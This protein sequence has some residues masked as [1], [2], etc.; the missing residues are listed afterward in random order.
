MHMPPHHLTTVQSGTG[1]A[2]EWLLCGYKHPTAVFF[3]YV[4][5]TFNDLKLKLYMWLMVLTV[6]LADPVQE[7][8]PSPS[9]LRRRGK[10]P[11]EPDNN[12][13]GTWGE[14]SGKTI[15]REI[16]FPVYM[17]LC[18]YIYDDQFQFYKSGVFSW[19]V[20]L[21]PSVAWR[22]D[23]LSSCHSVALQLLLSVFKSNQV[24]S[25]S[26]LSSWATLRALDFSVS[27]SCEVFSCCQRRCSVSHK[28][29]AFYQGR[30]FL[31]SALFSSS[32]ACWVLFTVLLAS[33]FCVRR[34]LL[35]LL[36][37]SC[38]L[39]TFA[40]SKTRLSSSSF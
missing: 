36:C 14:T 20:F 19:R 1:S 4:I 10:T 27:S 39:W 40:L 5:L 30:L 17:H 2:V 12:Q 23:D 6:G 3:L 8:I 9:S 38:S 21:R 25:F 35:I 31:I 37:L 32:W 15:Q 28:S 34:A 24:F 29:S 16:P 7:Q 11:H 33:S 13:D 18:L 22:R 26:C